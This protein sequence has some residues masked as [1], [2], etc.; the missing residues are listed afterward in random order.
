MN[1]IGKK[2]SVIYIGGHLGFFYEYA[3][4]GFI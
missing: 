4:R 3:P 2:L 1:F